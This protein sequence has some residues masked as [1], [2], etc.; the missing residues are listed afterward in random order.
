MNILLI[1]I[2]L[3]PESKLKFFPVGIGYIATA[4]KNAGFAFDLV[5]IDAHR[6]TDAEVARLIAQKTY[7]VVC[8]GCLVTGYKEV[9]K[10]CAMVRRNQPKCTIVVGN[11]VATSIYGT[12]LEKTEADVAV[13]GEGD[14]TIVSVLKALERK[15]PLHNIEGI[16]FLSDGKIVVTPRR[17]IIGD[18]SI[19]P[20]IDYDL[21]DVDIYLKNSSEQ[22]A[23]GSPIPREQ[24]RTLP[25]N[26][27]RGCIG[28]CT[29]CYHNFQGE[30][31][32]YRSVEA[33]VS[34]IRSLVDKYDL[35]HISFWDELSLFS[36]K[37]AEE[38]AD[39]ILDSGLKFYWDGSCRADCFGEDAD[40]KILQKLKRAGCIRLGYSLESSNPEILAAMNK[41][42]TVEQ[43]ARTTRLIR[44]SG[45]I[46][47]T[48][49][50]IGFPQETV[51]TIRHTLATCA[52][53]GIY[54]SAGYLLPQPGS[55]IYDYAR[56]HGYINDEEEYLLKLGDRQDLRINMTKIP[57]RE[58]E[59][60]VREGLR[61][62]NASLGCE[63]ADEHI[64]KTQVYRAPKS[65]GP[66]TGAE[67]E[68]G[69]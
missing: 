19:L 20:N 7:D 48:S 11:S 23:D 26:T 50:V 40:I 61:L 63:L 47:G 25:V 28:R 51:D 22:I 30:R 59:E 54:P 16:C 42:I 49:L 34:E 1:N 56:A 58:L 39:A 68:V 55:A 45:L 35:N 62:C 33:I 5:D 53:N 14:A 36:K 2:S 46:P 21:F 8:M 18:L 29:F 66:V 69:E 9:K 17:P 38:L 27:A 64:I 4:M 10:L 15:E 57:D 6:Y 43:F 52:E 60:T 31:Y 12:L 32:R 44:E 41:H 37:R 13:M 3:R 24:V 65:L 67:D